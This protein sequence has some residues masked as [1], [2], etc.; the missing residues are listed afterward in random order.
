MI[1]NARE[2]VTEVGSD[3][4]APRFLAKGG[5]IGD[6]PAAAAI[7]LLRPIAKDAKDGKTGFR[8]VRDTP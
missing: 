7:R 4:A 3:P 2:I 6:P 8:C 1:G 5:G